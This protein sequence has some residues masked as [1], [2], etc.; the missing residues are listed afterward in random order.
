MASPTM[1]C[2]GPEQED[3]CKK[4][5]QK[6]DDYINRERPA[7]RDGT[8]GLK[9]RFPEQI[10]GAN[11]PGT[12]AW[13]THDTEIKNQQENLRKQLENYN[14]QGCGDPPPGAWSWVTRPAPKPS[15][16]KGPSPQQNN[17]QTNKSE[18]AA[19]VTGAVVLYFIISEGSRIVFPPRNLI[20]V[21]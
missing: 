10:N 12:P 20:P 5:A 18:D 2:C 15:E 4:I 17:Q 1:P 9:F 6:I 14:K 8:K 13:N 7:P 16:W 21:W 19:L 11:G 3:K